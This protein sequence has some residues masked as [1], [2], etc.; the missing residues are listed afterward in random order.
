[1]G[2]RRNIKESTRRMLY[3]RSGNMCA[4]YG[5]NNVLIN[6]N[7][8]N[9]SEI[10]HIEA[11]NDDGVRYND[12]LT[13]EVIVTVIATGFDDEVGEEAL[14]SDEVHVQKRRPTPEVHDE[15]EIPPFLRS[16]NY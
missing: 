6:E 1:M 11:V 12:N 8:S 9:I 5:C 2:Y 15:Y 13:D 16:D 14:F 10:C 3:A 7:T 4:M